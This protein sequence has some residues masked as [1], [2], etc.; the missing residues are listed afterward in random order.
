MAV[1]VGASQ[2]VIFLGRDSC[3]RWPG[4]RGAG[5][6]PRPRQP[7]QPPEERYRS[8]LEQLAAMGFINRE[9]NLQGAISIEF[10]FLPLWFS[11]SSQAARGHF[12]FFFEES[13]L[14]TSFWL[15]G[16]TCPESKCWLGMK[17]T[18]GWF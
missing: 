2:N 8:Q 6:P 15:T 4:R 1:E 13:F 14:E 18:S 10:F 3:R 9:A 16:K 7:Q 17:P 11:F 12:V 5:P